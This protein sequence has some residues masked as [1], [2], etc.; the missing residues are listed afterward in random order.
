ML[1]SDRNRFGSNDDPNRAAGP[2]AVTYTWR[3]CVLKRITG[4]GRISPEL[5]LLNCPADVTTNARPGEVRTR[6]AAEIVA[7]PAYQRLALVAPCGSIPLFLIALFASS[8]ARKAINRLDPSLSFEPTSIAALNTA[9]NCGRWAHVLAFQR[10]RS[11][12]NARET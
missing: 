1:Q 2:S 3:G 6:F 7:S 4:C 10:D 8:E 12:W 5:S 11:N 9:T